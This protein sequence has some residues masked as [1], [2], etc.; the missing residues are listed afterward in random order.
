ML[1]GVSILKRSF[2]KGLG[3]LTIACSLAA[4]II[5]AGPAVAANATSVSTSTSHIGA[6][7]AV[8]SGAVKKIERTGKTTA[9]LNVRKGTKAST[10]KLGTL[11]RGSKVTITGQDSK[12]KW[13]RISYKGKTGYISNKYV[14]LDPVKAP[15]KPKPAKPALKAPPKVV[16]K[17]PTVKAPAKKAT[18]KVKTAYN[19][20]HAGLTYSVIDGGVNWN[21]KVGKMTF[22][23]GDFY[24][25]GYAKSVSE[26]PTGPKAKA[27]AKVAAQS[28]M[29]LVIP[30][31]PDYT[32]GMG[33]T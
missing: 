6:V 3:S 15:A 20:K 16:A 10:A 22:L 14:K 2:T 9:A 8:V 24:A 19:Q 17:K 5:V 21:T 32:K 29:V 7:Q 23:D 30:K 28:N 13:Y 25:R 4:S 31:I 11:S 33:Y 27:M 1:R 12:T 18:A 26:H